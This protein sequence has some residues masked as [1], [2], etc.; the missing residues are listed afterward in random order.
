MLISWIIFSRL[1]YPKPLDDFKKSLL[2][3][4]HDEDTHRKNIIKNILWFCV[5]MVFLLLNVVPAMLISFECNKN[6]PLHLILAFIF[7][8][9]YVLHYT[10]RKFVMRDNYCNI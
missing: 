4:T 6:S 1:F 10:Y 7:S 9:I 5:I 2:V 3:K 8:D